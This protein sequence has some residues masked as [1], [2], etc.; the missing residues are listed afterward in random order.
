MKRNA[1]RALQIPIEHDTY[2]AIAIVNQPERRYRTRRQPEIRH[3]PLGRRETQLAVSD[4]LRHGPKIRLLRRHHDDEVM[5]RPLLIAQEEIL[6]MR[7]ID[8]GPV[9]LCFLH[10][11]SRR[12]LV[13]RERN[14]KLTEPRDDRLLLRSHREC[15]LDDDVVTADGTSTAAPSIRPPRRSSSARFAASS[16]YSRTCVTI[17][18]F[19]ASS[20]KS[21]AS[22]RVRLATERTTRSRHSRL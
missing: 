12:M 13:A 9:P 19:G 1:R 8:V 15:G 21:R 7:R 16:G 17:G 22:R 20:R 3:Q 5:S 6:A 10:C 18:I 11:R 14:S 4:L 2:A